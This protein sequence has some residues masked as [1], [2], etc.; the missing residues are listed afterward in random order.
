MVHNRCPHINALNDAI[1][2][3]TP[4]VLSSFRFKNEKWL[5]AEAER[6]GRQHVSHTKLSRRNE[7]SRN[8]ISESRDERREHME[9]RMLP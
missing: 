7:A 3:K 9:Q 6:I 8:K 4:P 1:V 2:L 5:K